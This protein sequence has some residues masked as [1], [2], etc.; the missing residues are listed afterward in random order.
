LKKRSTVLVNLISG[1]SSKQ[2][3]AQAELDGVTYQMKTV[4]AGEVW[5]F[6]SPTQ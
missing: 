2:Q 5:L 1:L 3:E 4:D 6:A